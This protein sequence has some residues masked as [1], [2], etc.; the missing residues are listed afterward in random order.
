MFLPTPRPSEIAPCNLSRLSHH[1][2]SF[3]PLVQT[4]L[5]VL[6]ATVF[7]CAFASSALAAQPPVD[8]KTAKSF[9]LLAGSEITNTG[10]STVNGDLG[11]SPGTAVSGFPPGTLNGAA[12]ITNAVAG[13]AKNDLTT[14]YNDAAGRTPALS[15]P[16]DLGGMTATAGVYS[17]SSSLGLTGAMTLDAQ[18]DPNAVFIFKAGS[19]LTTASGSR[20]N[21]IN[22]AQ[23]CNVF[24]QIGSSATLGTSSV[25]NGN[26]LALTSVSLNNAVTVNGR[27]LARNGAVTLINDT[28]NRA[29]CAA[30]TV[31]GPGG[32]GIG[33]GPDGGTAANP[34]NGS[35]ILVTTPGWIGRQIQRDGTTRCIDRSFKVVVR[36]LRIDRV[37][38]MSGKRVIARRDRAPFSASIPDYTGGN[39]VIRALV[40]FTDRTPRA[41]LRMRFKA[42]GEASSAVPFEPVGFTG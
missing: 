40:Y 15:V 12:H 3:L 36:G 41:V 7:V 6:A 1:G 38:F 21:L 17:S 33:D 2:P 16:A 28:I 9:A 26:I 37:V 13:I 8:L 18:G 31:G 35:A 10:P 4:F 30:G 20:V 11:L 23:A 19:S 39:H 34:G 29:D 22:G 24:W 42:C 27:I 32:P 5:A 25:L 14:A